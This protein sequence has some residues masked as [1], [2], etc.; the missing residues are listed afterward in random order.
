MPQEHVTGRAVGDIAGGPQLAEGLA[1]HGELADEVREAA[2]CRVPAGG[3]PQ[4]RHVDS[5]SSPSSPPRCTSAWP[6]S[7]P[8]ADALHRP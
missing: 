1:A 5:R 6:R 7:R 8:E 2:V 3:Q 4:I